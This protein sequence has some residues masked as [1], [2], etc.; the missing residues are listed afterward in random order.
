VARV[1]TV[2]PA[3][4]LTSARLWPL[5]VGALVALPTAAV[6]WPPASDLSLHE[7]MVALLLHHGDSAFVPP[8]LYD[9]QLGHGNQLF[10][11]LALPF[12]W[13]FGPGLACRLVLAAIVAATVAAAAHLAEH[14]GRARVAALSIV[15]AALGWSFYW[16]FAPQMLGFALLL[17][18]LPLLDAAAERGS[19]LH[20]GL[21]S[22]AMG[23]LGLAHVTSMICACVATVIFAL[24][25]PLDRRTPLRVAPAV[26]GAALALGEAAWESRTATPLAKLF[27]SQVLWHSPGKKVADL[28]AHVVGRHGTITEATLGLLIVVTAVLW[29]L[30]DAPPTVVPDGAPVPEGGPRVWAARHRFSILA[31]TLFAL[32][33][34]APYSVNFGAFLYVRFL[35]PAFALSML[36]LAP[37]AGSRG[38]LVVVPSLALAV[39]PLVA[40]VP[41]LAAAERQ[42]RA[43][44]PLLAR[45]DADSAVA[46]LHFGKHDRELLFD[47]T[48]F[49]NRV[50][51]ERG[52]REV[53]SF[54]EYPIAPV[55][56]RPDLRWDALLLRL[57]MRPDA[58]EPAH[59]F[60]YVRWLLA[61]VHETALAPRIVRAIAPEAQLV[62]TSGEWLLFR[63]TLP[64]VPVASP[65][66]PPDPTAETVQQRDART[67]HEAR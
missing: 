4:P 50:L 60:T 55:V 65:E 23:V 26:F 47:P 37:R 15:P 67:S 25:R 7:G 39:A 45:I 44:E 9:L 57:S 10:Y 19:P 27:A 1:A 2:A 31:A 30:P 58:L 53:F 6:R 41:Q 38:P 64:V 29:R 36:L 56:V 20:A 11:F 12:A 51:A 32:Y 8:G 16:G 18:L 52:G 46:V 14:L 59:D 17:G 34:A 24:V 5:G 13:A 66:P 40:A 49:G 43:V 21:A 22:L 28:V 61:H 42:A 3:P 54:A 33:F 35:A 48:S 63:S 62:D